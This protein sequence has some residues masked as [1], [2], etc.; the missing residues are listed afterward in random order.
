MPALLLFESLLVGSDVLLAKDLCIYV[1]GA[2]GSLVFSEFVHLMLSGMLLKWIPDPRGNGDTQP[3]W[4]KRCKMIR[5]LRAAFDNA[6][7]DGDNKL[8]KGELEIVLMSLSC[9]CPTFP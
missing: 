3:I 8:E 9:A 2:D 7:V 5:L 1:P 4:Q 6:D